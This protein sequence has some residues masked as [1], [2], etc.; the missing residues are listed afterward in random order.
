MA[1]GPRIDRGQPFEAAMGGGEH[2]GAVGGHL[3]LTQNERRPSGGETGETHLRGPF[4][5][6]PARRTP[7]PQTGR[8]GQGVRLRAARAVF[9]SREI[10]IHNRMNPDTTMLSVKAVVMMISG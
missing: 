9:T 8:R 2:F 10:R 1:H 7:P 4:A 3:L 5:I 6:A